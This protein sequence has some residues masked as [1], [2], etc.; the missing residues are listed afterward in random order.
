MNKILRS[1]I[2]LVILIRSVTD[3]ACWSF[4]HYEFHHL[5]TTLSARWVVFLI[6]QRI[7]LILRA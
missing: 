6:T 2:T 5:K 1:A 4:R 7:P 3:G